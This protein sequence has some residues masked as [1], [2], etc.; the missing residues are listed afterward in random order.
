MKEEEQRGETP[1]KEKISK[2][3][4]AQRAHSSRSSWGGRMWNTRASLFDRGSMASKNDRFFFISWKL[5][6]EKDKTH[7]FDDMSE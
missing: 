5:L 1:D 4:Q 2:R 7:Y 6:D 3:Q